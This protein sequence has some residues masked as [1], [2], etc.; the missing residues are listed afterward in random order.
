MAESSSQPALEVDPIYRNSLREAKFILGLWACCFVWTVGYCYFYGYLSHEPLAG[1][2]GPAVT[3]LL[4][5]LKSF[6][7]DPKSL[8]Y[9]LDLGVP[10][11]AFY[12]IVL[13][14]VICTVLSFWYGLFFFAEDDLSDGADEEEE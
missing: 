2:T 1:S 6:D 8:T 5:P 14:W 3:N 9:P 13:P 12:G 4:G 10:D 11:W 7:R